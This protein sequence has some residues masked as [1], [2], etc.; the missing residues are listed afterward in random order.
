MRKLYLP[1]MT[2]VALLACSGDDN[3]TVAPLEI[4]KADYLTHYAVNGTPFTF[5]SVNPAAVAIPH[6]GANQTWDFSRFDEI[7][8]SNFGGRDFI[9]PSSSAYAHATYAYKGNTSWVVGGAES[10]QF[11]KTTFAEISDSGIYELG[12]SQEIETSIS[13]PA[14]GAEISFPIQN[15]TYKE[16]KNPHVHF[17]LKMGNEPIT[18]SGIV[19]FNDYTVNAPTF[20]LNNTPGRTLVTTSVT[21]EVIASGKVYLKGIGMKRV[22]I[23]KSSFIDITNYFLGGEPTP[24]VLLAN[25]G[26]ED[27]TTSTSVTYR[28]IA[29]GLGTV[30]FIYTNTD[31]VVTGASFRKS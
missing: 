5:F 27:G 18:T 8:T 31:G 6:E 15:L 26:L 7:A 14:L 23:Q 28:F 25:L 22:L 9:T 29:E 21:H 17:P 12:Y 20:G 24:A 2:I 19:L 10:A 16:A 11:P 3:Q 1:F 4:T 30:G 13:I